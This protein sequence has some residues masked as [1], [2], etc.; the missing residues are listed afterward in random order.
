VNTHQGE[1]P[2][3][4]AG[5]IARPHRGGP[6][7]AGQ[8]GDQLPCLT[9]SAAAA[10]KKALHTS[11]RA[12]ERVQTRRAAFLETGQALDAHRLQFVDAAGATLAM[13]RRDG[14]ATPGQRVVDHGPDNYGPNQTMVAALGLHGLEAPW[15]VDSASNGEIFHCWVSEVLGPTLQPGDIVLWDNLSAHKVAGGGRTAGEAGRTAPPIVA[16]FARL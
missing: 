3:C 15:G 16:L 6:G 7:A 10:Q 12:T 2:R 1:A 4:H 5:R 14:R 9:T 13:I 8:P 11:A